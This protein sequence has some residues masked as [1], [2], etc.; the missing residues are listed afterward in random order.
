MHK[1]CSES[2]SVSNM[3]RFWLHEGIFKVMVVM[4]KD[5]SIQFEGHLLSLLFH[6]PFHVRNSPNSTRF[7]DSLLSDLLFSSRGT[8]SDEEQ[9]KPNYP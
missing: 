6:K 5:W 7:F 2:F 9:T 8:C 1:L 4:G 3:E